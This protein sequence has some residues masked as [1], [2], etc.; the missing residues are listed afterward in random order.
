MSA[1]I[2]PTLLAVDLEDYRSQLGKVSFADRI[3]IDISDGEF[4]D[5][6]TIQSVEAHWPDDMAAD[7]HLMVDHPRHNLEALLA[8]RPNLIIVHAEA[9]AVDE[10]LAFLGDYQQAAGLA[11]LPQT[12]IETVAMKLASVQHCLIFGGQL[13]HMGGEADLAQLDKIEQIRE[14]NPDVEIGWDGGANLENV[15]QLAAAGVDVINV[16]SAIH[17]A[18]NPEAAYARLNSVVN[19]GK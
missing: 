3:Q 19:E 7:F 13:G 8:K 10:A 6:H 2:A 11:L 14:I 18:S 15:Q 1:T 17:S 9:T 4:T 16:G 5:Q 12:H